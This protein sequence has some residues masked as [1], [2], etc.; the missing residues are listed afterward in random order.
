MKYKT[1]AIIIGRKSRNKDDAIYRQC[2]ISLF[3]VNDPHKQNIVPKEMIEFERA[4]RIDLEGFK[5]KFMLMGGDIVIN[6]L[7]WIDVSEENG[8]VKVTGKQG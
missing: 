8:N 3:D 2:F 6:N 4:K 1:K 5:I 7:Q